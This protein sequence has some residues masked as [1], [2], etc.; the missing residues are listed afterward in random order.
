M[1][2]QNAQTCSAYKSPTQIDVFAA[3]FEKSASERR[4]LCRGR[5]NSI[6]PSREI[7]FSKSLSAKIAEVQVSV[8]GVVVCIEITY[9]NACSPILASNDVLSRAIVSVYLQFTVT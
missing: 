9:R 1:R 3:R 2:R 8:A 6:G 7:L 5:A 4:A